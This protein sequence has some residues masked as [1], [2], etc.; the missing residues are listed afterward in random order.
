M[1]VVPGNTRVV[2]GAVQTAKGTPATTPTHKFSLNSDSAGN[3]GREIIQLPETDASMQRPDNTVVGSSPVLEW[4]NWV[5]GSEFAFLAKGIQGVNVDAGATTFTHTATPAQQLPYYTFW[6]VV[7][8]AQCTRFD[9][10][11][12][13]SL[14]VSGEALA[15][16]AYTVSIVSLSATLGV[17][18][19]TLPA[20]QASDQKYSYPMVTVT[21]GGVAPGTFDAF[22]LTI[23]RNVAV[24]RGDLGLA[25]YDSVGGIYAVEGTAR[26]IYT[27]D[28]DFRKFHGGSAAATTLTTTIFSESLNL[29]LQAATD[30]KVVFTSSAIEY[31]ETTVPVN[32]D[33]AP[34]LSELAFS[35]KRQA[36]WAN[37]LT[38]VTTNTLATAD[39]SPA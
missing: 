12:F 11:R 2:Y 32:V 35:T 26:K 7:P 31:T 4:T 21:I 16:I 6:D 10:C 20:A 25:S 24:L 33:G 36:T 28:A 30:N 22:S 8:G 9:D 23:N 1:P 19:P 38:V 37:N 17:T 27:S 29:Q 34:I 5:R 15:G 14:A 13:S 39:T 3:P 18:A